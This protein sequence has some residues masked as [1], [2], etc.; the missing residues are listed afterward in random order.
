MSP[1]PLS[2]RFGSELCF[3]KGK[4]SGQSFLLSRCPGPQREGAPLWLLGVARTQRR[5]GPLFQRLSSQDWDSPFPVPASRTIPEPFHSDSITPGCSY[6]HP[7]T[8]ESYLHPSHRLGMS[9]A[10]HTLTVHS[11]PTTTT[12]TGSPSMASCCS[13]REVHLP[14]SLPCSPASLSSLA[15]WQHHAETSKP[16]AFPL[17]LAR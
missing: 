2:P 13:Q 15:P 17:P 4:P 3:W 1:A 14:T 16:T 10:K 8:L 7:S 9:S 12:T 5:E 6:L 11:S